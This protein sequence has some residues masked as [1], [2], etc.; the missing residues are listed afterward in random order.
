M[1]G[2]GGAVSLVL[3]PKNQPA[4]TFVESL[5]TLPENPR[6]P[7]PNP[8]KNK[9]FEEGTLKGQAE[10]MRVR[11]GLPAPIFWSGVG[12]KS[13]NQGAPESYGGGR[14]LLGDGGSER[15]TQAQR[16]ELVR[17]RGR[18]GRSG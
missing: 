6:E 17:A 16:G 14:H 2:E 11:I 9:W 8:L 12:G 1:L 18:G 3:P 13:Y 5:E 7:R 15:G 10:S 4:A